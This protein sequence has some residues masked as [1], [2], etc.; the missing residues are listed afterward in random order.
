MAAGDFKDMQDAVLDRDYAETDRTAVK[1]FLNEAYR[2][3]MGEYRWRWTENT[4]TINTVAGTR[5]YTLPTN[6]LFV[7]RIVDTWQP[8]ILGVDRAGN[9]QEVDTYPVY[10]RYGAVNQPFA[11]NAAS[12][13]IPTQWY[14]MSN[15]VVL[16]PTPDKSTYQYDVYLHQTNADMVNDT[17]VPGTSATN[18][19]PIPDRDC[20]VYGALARMA[21]RDRNFT[22]QQMMLERYKSE[23]SNAIK[24]QE[25][26]TKRVRKAHM[27]AHYLGRFDGDNR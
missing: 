15:L 23:L 24:R 26:S 20:L 21:E 14:R 7:N 2:D 19:M 4:S 12:R 18:P 25:A 16:M 17:D 1:R 9:P 3:V 13:G 27:P 8:G 11:T 5:N 6:T 22:L 10:D